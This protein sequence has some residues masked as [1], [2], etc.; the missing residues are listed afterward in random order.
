MSTSLEPRNH[1]ILTSAGADRPGIV[2]DLSGWIL[3]HGGNIEDSRMSQLG[4]EF[5]TLILVSGG[6]GLA[7]SLR[8][9]AADFGAAHGLTVTC[10]PVA[11]APPSHGRPLLRYTLNATSLDHPGVVH[12]VADLLRRL[13]I[14]IV[15]AATRVT[16]A[17]FSGA[18]VFQFTMT[19]DIPSDVNVGGVRTA[20]ADLGNRENMDL[21]L[22]QARVEV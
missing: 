14:N 13:G 8:A 21:A 11:A 12:P 16:S 17:P 4:G 2:A 22:D 5:A 9:T 10:R 1:V 3:E 18:S 20:L 7:E 15:S 19:V 6:P